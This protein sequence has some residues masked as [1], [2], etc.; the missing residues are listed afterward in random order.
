MT[1]YRFRAAACTLIG[2][3]ILGT[4]L[5]WTAHLQKP[6]IGDANAIAGGTQFTGPLFLVALGKVALAL[7]FSPRR[8]LA[9]TGIFLLAIYGAGFAFGEITELFQ[10]NVGISAGRWDIVLA[11]SVLGAIIGVT[12]AVLAVQALVRTRRA[13]RPV[14]TP[15]N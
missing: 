3:N 10:H 13:G 7:T 15:A 2:F 4:L 6:A 11:G 9:R 8:W 1:T 5:T 14:A 12:D